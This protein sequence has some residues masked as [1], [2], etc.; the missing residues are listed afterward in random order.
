MAK[1]TIFN[2]RKPIVLSRRAMALVYIH[3]DPSAG[4]IPYE[5]KFSTGVTVQLLSDGS[6]RLVRP[7]GKPLFR[8]FA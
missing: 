4:T 3:A 8:K 1:L 2:P 7:D 6:V 5:H